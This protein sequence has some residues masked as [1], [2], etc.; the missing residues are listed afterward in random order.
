MRV[1]DFKR[2]RAPLA[3]PVADS[4]RSRENW[5]GAVVC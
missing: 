4:L 5:T 3:V 1:A 2:L